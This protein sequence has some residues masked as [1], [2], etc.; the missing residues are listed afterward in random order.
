MNSI[1]YFF[2]NIVNLFLWQRTHDRGDGLQPGA[3]GPLRPAQ[4]R[5]RPHGRTD[6]HLK[7]RQVQCCC[8]LTRYSSYLWLI[9]RNMKSLKKNLSLFLYNTVYPLLNT[10]YLFFCGV[11]VY[12]FSLDLIFSHYF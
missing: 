10:H 3:R 4:G 6:P 9:E 2:L 7:A 5:L 11:M 8:D 12:F 1:Y